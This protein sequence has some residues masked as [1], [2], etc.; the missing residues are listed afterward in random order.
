VVPWDPEAAW[1]PETVFFTTLSNLSAN[2][3]FFSG[4][5]GVEEELL[6]E[7][8]GMVMGIV[9]LLGGGDFDNFLGE[10]CGLS[11]GRCWDRD[12]GRPRPIV[13]T[14]SFF[15][16]PGGETKLK[17]AILLVRCEAIIVGLVVN[18]ASRTF[19]GAGGGDKLYELLVSD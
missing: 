10:R 7:T 11:S 13:L 16:V 2:G 17:G 8:A 5:L 19:S 1:S 9:A 12:E 14:S 4:P 3:S 6:D 15:G 18:G